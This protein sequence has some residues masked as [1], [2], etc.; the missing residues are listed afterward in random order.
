M[1]AIIVVIVVA[2]IAIAAFVIEWFNND[3][4]HSQIDALNRS[5]EDSIL[6]LNQE[7][8]ELGTKLGDRALEVARL[9]KEADDLTSQL[10]DRVRE[11][12]RLKAELD[13]ALDGNIKLSVH[14]V[15]AEAALKKARAKARRQKG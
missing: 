2:V 9:N 12:H 5:A 1:I 7:A 15:R 6:Q 11:V 10:A 13:R 4:L 8:V 3:A 14:V